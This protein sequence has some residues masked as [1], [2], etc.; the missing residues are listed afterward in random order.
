MKSVF[1]V[2]TIMPY[3]YHN[4]VSFQ[5]FVIREIEINY[6]NLTLDLLISNLTKY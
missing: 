1:M 4:I 3:A 6:I 5:Q 2:E